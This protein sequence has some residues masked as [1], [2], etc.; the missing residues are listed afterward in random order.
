MPEDLSQG[1]TYQVE[2]YE[3]RYAEEI[4]LL[5]IMV[6][7]AKWRRLIAATV[8]LFAVGAL[9]FA[10]MMTPLYKASVLVAETDKSYL[11]L[12]KSSAVQDRVLDIFAPKNWREM[13]GPDKRIKRGQLVKEY[14][15]E[16]DAKGTK[17]GVIELSV[18]YTDPKK[19]AEIAN[20]YV[21]ALENVLKDVRYGEYR[22]MAEDYAG[23]LNEVSGNLRAIEKDLA[24]LEGKLG[25]GAKSVGVDGKIRD[26]EPVV[27][28]WLKL[29]E[30]I[31]D[32][33]MLISEKETDVGNNPE[34]ATMKEE[35]SELNLELEQYEES[36]MKSA[37]NGQSSASFEVFSEYLKKR[38]EWLVQ[39]MLYQ[40]LQSLYDKV[41]LQEKTLN[42]S[43]VSLGSA[44]V[45][46]KPFKPNKKLLLAV[47]LVLGLFIGVFSAFF[48]EFFHRASEDPEER[49]KVKLIKEAFTLKGFFKS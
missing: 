25:I 21:N 8:L 12:L 19:A 36:I 9:I 22:K 23:K 44:Q 42:V 11:G 48:M 2:P 38:K 45:P 27:A 35:L 34:V 24:E 14:I 41:V 46:D 31:M 7:F 18:T 28:E 20:E 47:A 16:M 3:G 15:G 6:I 39:W 17:D 26:L 40:K 5:D 49:E 30:K 37:L 13:V 10:F 29:Q 1:R 33:V 43:V 32:K 4:S